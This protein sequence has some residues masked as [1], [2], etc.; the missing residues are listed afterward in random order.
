MES[1]KT[2]FVSD[3]LLENVVF[4]AI[5]VFDFLENPRGFFGWTYHL[6][7]ILSNFVYMVFIVIETA[8]GPNYYD[9]DDNQA[10]Y[11]QLPTSHQY[12]IIKLF[13][14]VPLMCHCVSRLVLATFLHFY[15]GPYTERTFSR[16]FEKTSNFLL[17]IWFW[18]LIITSAVPNLWPRP[19]MAIYHCIDF[20]R[21]LQIIQSFK[22]VPSFVVVK[23]TLRRVARLVPIPVFI[24]FVFNIFVGVILYLVDPC[25]N[26]D[27]CPFETLFDAVFFCIVTMTTSKYIL[28]LKEISLIHYYI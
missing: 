1:I 25:F 2:E 5:K 27:T 26:R 21:H 4:N 14:S 23:E 20:L 22:E 12:L 9:S 16:F 28:N 7:L 11:K 24:F 19:Y 8:D 18:P 17:L 6:F 10:L 13:F 3:E 15:S